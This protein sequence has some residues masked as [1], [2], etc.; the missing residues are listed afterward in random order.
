MHV[1]STPPAYF[2]PRSPHGERQS[3]LL[4]CSSRRYF[5]PR[6]PHGERHQA[7]HAR[8][9]GKQ[10]FNPRSPHGERH[11]RTATGAERFSFQPTLPARGATPHWLQSAIGERFQPTLPARGATRMRH[12]TPRRAAI[13]THAPRTGSDAAEAALRAVRAAFQPTLPARGATI[14]DADGFCV[15]RYFNPRSPHGER[16]IPT[17]ALS[18]P[19]HFNPRSPHGERQVGESVTFTVVQFQPTLPARGATR[20]Q[21]QRVRAGNISTHAPRTGSDRRR[22]G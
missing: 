13:S 17:S 22:A 1:G 14:C 16:P 19:T 2:N 10:Y 11:Q 5:N 3:L 18:Y 4:K 6:S 15:A 7:G 21:V 9:G 12:A 8:N 20:L